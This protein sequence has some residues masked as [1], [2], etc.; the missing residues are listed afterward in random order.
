MDV[1]AMNVQGDKAMGP[2]IRDCQ[3]L[4]DYEGNQNACGSFHSLSIHKATWAGLSFELATNL[5]GYKS[6][7]RR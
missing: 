4:N 5:L 2:L 6:P 3:A 7:A 1:G